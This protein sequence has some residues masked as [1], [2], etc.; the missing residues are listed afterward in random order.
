MAKGTNTFH[1]LDVPGL[2][3]D[4]VEFNPDFGVMKSNIGDALATMAARLGGGN[5]IGGTS[6]NS[7]AGKIIGGS[8]GARYGRIMGFAT[9]DDAD[10]VFQDHGADPSTGTDKFV[11]GYND[12]DD[13][14][15][16]TAGATLSVSGLVLDTSNN[17]GV[18][19]DPGTKLHVFQSSNG[20]VEVRAEN[21]SAG[22]AA[23][24]ILRLTNDDSSGAFIMHGSGH[25]SLA[26][27][28]RIANNNAAG[29]IRFFFNGADNMTLAQDGNVSVTG[30]FT[31]GAP[32][33]DY[34]F[35]DRSNLL[36]L[37]AKTAGQ[38][39]ALEFFAAD[40]DGSDDVS[41]HIYGVGTPSAVTNRERLILKF[42]QSSNQFLVQSEANGSGTLRSLAIET[43]GNTNQVFLQTGGGVGIKTA[44][45]DSYNNDYDDLV[46][47][48]A[49]NTGITIVSGTSNIGGI[50]MADGTPAGDNRRGFVSYHHSNITMQFGTNNAI[51]VTLDG[52]GRMGINETSPASRLHV[53]GTTGAAQGIRVEQ[54]NVTG[55]MHEGGGTDLAVGTSTNHKINLIINNTSLVQLTTDGGVH[56]AVQAGD[57]AV[58]ANKAMI[59]CKD[60][61]TVAEVY[62]QDEATNVSK[63]S[64]HNPLTG[65]YYFTSY[66]RTTG[67]TL[68]I[69]MERLVKFL[70]V[71]VS[72]FLS[73]DKRRVLASMVEESVDPDLVAE[74]HAMV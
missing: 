72:P 42:V 53:T 29:D 32:S 17:L 40:G 47:A 69:H 44:T 2:I 23:R 4:P 5:A 49:G 59:F 56:F 67:R 9:G 22:N 60:D 8:K 74:A 30:H 55:V 51:R 6:A 39:S 7:N 25:A 24:T 16:V 62:V 11:A 64:P 36:T 18:G 45:P 31:I 54:T 41:L 37:Q 48:T 34:E 27:V 19:V 12:G 65:E 73:E 15:G 26:D 61:A 58:V 70:I 1:D 35:A 66:N 50:S 63:I 38:A 33:Q 14:F 20:D 28:F 68:T 10:L 71:E 57:P 46:V 13:V 43:E 52:N 3:S 21:D